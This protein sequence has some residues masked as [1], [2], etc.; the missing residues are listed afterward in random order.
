MSRKAWAGSCCSCG[1]RESGGRG[2]PR[3]SRLVHGSCTSRPGSIVGRYISGPV[4][5]DRRSVGLPLRRP[6]FRASS[7]D[8]APATSPPHQRRQRHHHVHLVNMCGQLS[9]NRR[10]CDLLRK[11]ANSGTC[12]VH[13]GFSPGVQFVGKGITSCLIVF[14]KG[15]QSLAVSHVDSEHVVSVCTT[16]YLE[17]GLPVYI[18]VFLAASLIEKVFAISA[19]CRNGGKCISDYGVMTFQCSTCSRIEIFGHHRKVILNVFRR[20]EIIYERQKSCE[21][22]EVI[23]VYP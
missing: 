16:A 4:P 11:E 18:K 19:V 22:N 20:A 10:E 8:Q 14:L 9:V 2:G 6:P 7:H 21:A 23:G 1:S 5:L 3:R 15:D 17:V 12:E 13:Q